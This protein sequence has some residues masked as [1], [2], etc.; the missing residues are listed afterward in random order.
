VDQEHSGFDVECTDFAVHLE[1]DVG[2]RDLATGR[3]ADDIPPNG[4]KFL[5]FPVRNGKVYH[6]E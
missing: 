4:I 6:H 1:L 5:V 2:H 3:E